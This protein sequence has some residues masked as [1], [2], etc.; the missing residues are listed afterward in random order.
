MA[1][2]TS[3][4]RITRITTTRTGTEDEPRA[5]RTFFSFEDKQEVKLRTVKINALR[6]L[7]VRDCQS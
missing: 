7:S 3:D 4:R 5:D 6:E 2:F 1:C